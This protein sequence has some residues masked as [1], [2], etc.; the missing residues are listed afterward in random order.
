MVHS[1]FE[2]R[3]EQSNRKMSIL[4]FRIIWNDEIFAQN[5]ET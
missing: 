1:K 3:L 5:T 2:W 4:F